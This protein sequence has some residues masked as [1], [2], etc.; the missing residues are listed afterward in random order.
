MKP[1][2]MI[3]IAIW[4]TGAETARE[5]E[6]WKTV[7]C[8][9]IVSEAERN[10]NVEIGPLTFTEKRPGDDRVPSVPAQISGPDVR[11]LV[12][13][14]KVAAGRPVILRE[15]GFAT[16]LD[17]KDLAR[18]RQITRRAHAKAHPGDRL[19]DRNCDQIIESLGPE[20]AVRTL[21]DDRKRVH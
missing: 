17:K 21:A 20:T 5:I 8:A 7:V 10:H 12:A 19:T 1:G 16:D 13:E 6:H 14:A 2:D 9:D 3:E 11:L 18:L 4:M 15:T